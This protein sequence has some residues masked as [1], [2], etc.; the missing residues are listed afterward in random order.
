M[1]FADVL[2]YVLGGAAIAASLGVVLR[3]DAVV[4]AMNL[5]L[6]FFCLSGVYLLLGFPFLAA[7]QVLVYAG[8]IMVLFLFVIMLLGVSTLARTPLSARTGIG[9]VVALAVFV[10][11]AI[12]GIE[13]GSETAPGAVAARLAAQ[14]G[15]APVRES[16]AGVSQL[17]FDGPLVLA[18]EITGVILLAAMV[19][20]VVLARRDPRVATPGDFA[21]QHA[22]D[23]RPL[24]GGQPAPA[25][26][27]GVPAETPRA[28]GA[29]EPLASDANPKNTA[30]TGGVA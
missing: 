21:R 24:V 30:V 10:E 28:V 14:R 1:T 16:V 17:L 3:R 15:I 13:L 5:V 20:V 2:G 29:N 12:L 26:P 9:A 25:I 4:A 8:A 6:A 11:L 23:P 7:I 18:F 22:F 27:D 19:G